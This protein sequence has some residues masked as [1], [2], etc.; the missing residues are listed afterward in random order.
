MTKQFIN[1]ID[2]AITMATAMLPTYLEPERLQSL[3][4]TLI[5]L[6]EDTQ[7]GRLHPSKGL[8]LGLNREVADWIQPLD[9]PLREP[10][11]AIDVCY[12]QH[13]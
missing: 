11:E 6:K 10:I 3:I 8:R 9:S 13:L 5:N 4:D 2:E 7:N 12:Q 1:L